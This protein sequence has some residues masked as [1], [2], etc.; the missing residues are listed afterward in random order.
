MHTQAWGTRVHGVSHGWTGHRHLQ[1]A[2]TLYVP[3]VQPLLLTVL[4]G[5]KQP[6]VLGTQQSW[7]HMGCMVSPVIQCLLPWCRGCFGGLALVSGAKDT[8]TGWSSMGPGMVER[9]P[10][11]PEPGPQGAEVPALRTQHVPALQG[12]LLSLLC[13]VPVVPYKQWGPRAHP[14]CPAVSRAGSVRVPTGAGTYGVKV[15]HKWAI[16]P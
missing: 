8:S 16:V 2:H 3:G 1:A 5:A 14:V 4:L 15:A 11:I 10:H 6:L 9:G 7:S 13:P 12:C